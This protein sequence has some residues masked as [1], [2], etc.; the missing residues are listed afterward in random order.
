M[1]K[2]AY[3][4]V[5]LFYFISAHAQTDDF[6]I[7]YELSFEK[8]LTD[9]LTVGLEESLRT[10]N[11]ASEFKS[12]NNDLGFK[13]TLS[14]FFSV[15][16]GYRYSINKYENGYFGKHR[17]YVTFNAEKE[18]N[19]FKFSYKNK[20]Q[21]N[22]SSYINEMSDLYPSYNDRN[23]LKIAY[24]IRGVKTDPYISA[25]TFHNIQTPS[26][27]SI[28]ETRYVVGVTRDLKF[29]SK[30]NLSFIYITEYDKITDHSYIV[31]ISFEKK[32]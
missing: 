7:W 21:I 25:E 10:F 15:N 1:K 3:I 9:K 18:I 30:I 16:L 22:K 12:F 28:T 31:S 11:N 32:F 19:D 13:Y 23:Y 2:V 29:K 4:L 27:Y 24:N 14:D 17:V 8:K 6:G 20:F 5:L 26:F